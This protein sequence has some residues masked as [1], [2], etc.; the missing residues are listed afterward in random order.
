MRFKFLLL[1]VVAASSLYAVPAMHRWKTVVQMDGS[2]MQVMLVGDEHL[3]YYITKDHVPLIK[4]NG[5]YYYADKIGY[6]MKATSLLAHALESRKA[7]E[8]SAVANIKSVAGMTPHPDKV[9]PAALVSSSGQ[10]MRIKAKSSSATRAMSSSY[11]GSRRGLVILVQFPDKKFSVSDPKTV[12]TNVV[13]EDNYASPFPFNTHGSVHDYFKDQSYGLFDLTFDVYGPV[14][15]SN[16]YAYYGQNDALGNDK[17]PG[18]MIVEGCK[19][20]LDS[21]G[22]DLSDYDW[23]GDGMVDQVF[24]LYAGQGEASGGD[25]NTI[26]P[27]EYNLYSSYYND[28]N[29]TWSVLNRDRSYFL[30]GQ[31]GTGGAAGKYNYLV[32]QVNS[33]SPTGYEIFNTYACSNEAYVQSGTSFLMGIGVICH[34][35]SHC[36]GFP[37][38]YD[39][40]GSNYGMGYLDL[41]NSGCYNGPYML[42][43]KPSG[44]TSYERHEAGWLNYSE[45]NDN[46]S[47]GAEVP[48]SENGAKAYKIVNPNHEDE[49]YLLENRQKTGWDTY[50][51]CAGLQV[52]HV[53]YDPAIWNANIVNTLGSV[54]SD[55]STVSN[56]HERFTILHADNSDKLRSYSDVVSKDE[57]GDLYPYIAEGVKNDSITDF[58]TPADFLYN[59]NRD[60]TRFLHISIMNITQN[61]DGTV[62]FQYNPVLAF[63]GNTTGILDSV[64][65]KD[66]E[67]AGIYDLNG[68]FIS[69]AETVQ[70]MPKGLYILKMRDGKTKKIV[71][72]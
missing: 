17:Y 6:G 36:L 30:P 56:D 44:Y 28:A 15:L 39:E 70:G 59:T 9:M 71:I 49:Y 25:V 55:S 12:F 4:K 26:W 54:A 33:K 60:G 50:I 69:S 40:T 48:I 66:N 29:G 31:N 32:Y 27:H 62:S 47:I 34:E 45:L 10:I 57:A 53:D 23:N 51:P 46:D 63:P 21:S 5:S 38:M 72:P 67:T 13:N 19:A 42:G 16:N 18:R 11:T 64:I 20:V 65:K 41:M 37:D 14:T 68:R 7:A 22:I 58:S 43:W 61:T 35:F 2:I 1:F 52:T 3:H 24:V 8:L